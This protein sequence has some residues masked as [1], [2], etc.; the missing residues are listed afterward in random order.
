M[1]FK[2]IFYVKHDYKNYQLVRKFLIDENVPIQEIELYDG[3]VIFCVPEDMYD[4]ILSKGQF[5]F[6]NQR[7]HDIGWIDGY[8]NILNCQYTKIATGIINPDMED[9]LEAFLKLLNKWFYFF[10]IRVLIDGYDNSKVTFIINNFDIGANREDFNDFIITTKELGINIFSN[11]YLLGPDGT[12]LEDLTY[13]YD[14]EQK[15]LFS[16]KKK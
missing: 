13:P 1:K 9:K 11:L 3:D 15:K 8:D 2:K 14:R 10:N 16:K 7:N 5:L 4:E 12:I 6:S